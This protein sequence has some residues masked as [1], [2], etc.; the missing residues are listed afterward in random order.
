VPFNQT[1][2]VDAS[3]LDELAHVS[4]LTWVRWIQEV[5][6]AH[7]AAVGWDWPA[8]QRLGAVFVVRRH[9]IDYLGPAFA[10][11]A[12][13]AT[14]WLEPPRGAAARRH[15]RITHA[16]DGRELLRAL[17]LW[18]LVDA[19]R[20]KPRRIPAELSAAFETR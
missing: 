10:G 4:N 15:T 20:G 2:G 13:Q 1:I 18:V 8:Y 12:L 5:A 3:D 6:R 17:T 14:T 19:Q 11:D 16:A 9:E 7:S